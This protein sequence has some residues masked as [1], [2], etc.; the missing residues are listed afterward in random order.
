[1][2]FSE[3]RDLKKMKSVICLII[4][5]TAL[6]GKKFLVEVEDGPEKE[7]KLSAQKMEKM[8]TSTLKTEGKD[9][10]EGLYLIHIAILSNFKHNMLY[11]WKALC[12]RT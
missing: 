9:Y 3:I 12:T 2:Q 5:Q 11:F 6:S 7:N 10:M 8:E 4:F 1:M